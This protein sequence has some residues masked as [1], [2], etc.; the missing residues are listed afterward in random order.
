VAVEVDWTE[1]AAIVAK[2]REMDEWP[3]EER[4]EEIRRLGWDWDR[5]TLQCEVTVRGQLEPQG[6]RMVVAEQCLVRFLGDF[7][8]MMNLASPGCCHLFRARVCRG[9]LEDGTLVHLSSELLDCAMWVARREGAPEIRSLPLASVVSWFDS[10]NIGGRQVAASRMERALFALL[11]VS[12]KDPGSPDVLMW[13]AHAIEALYD[14]TPGQVTRSLVNRVQRVLGI[15]ADKRRL[16]NR[17]LRDFYDLRSRFVHGDLA[18]ARPDHIDILGDEMSSHWGVLCPPIQFGAELL[19][20]TL[21][22][23]IS[24]GWKQIDFEEAFRGVPV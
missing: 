16:I 20:A 17:R 9:S 23:H 24:A 15:P 14:T 12:T 13:L 4:L 6:S 18:V 1:V 7:F 5:L 19:L 10:L 3:Q 2:D 8:T 22:R 21:Q 11:H